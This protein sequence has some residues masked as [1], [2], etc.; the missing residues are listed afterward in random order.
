MN[1]TH[2]IICNGD[3]SFLYRFDNFPIYMGISSGI[4]EYKDQN[5]Y[6]CKQCGTI[7]LKDLISL[8]KLYSVPHNPA[9]G[10]TWQRHNRNFADYITKYGKKSILEIGGGNCKI[11]DNV[12]SN[13]SSI[14][15][16]I[17]DKHA[18]KNTR[19][20]VIF[21]D[22]FYNPDEILDNEIYDTIVMSHVF[23]HIYDP[24]LYLQS[25]NKNLNV[26]GRVIFSIPN[27]TKILED[28][29][30]NGLN[31]E[32]TYQIDNK[33]LRYLM[34]KNGFKEISVYDYS[35]HNIFA[36]FE[37]VSNM[38]ISCKLNCFDQNMSIWKDFI[39]YHTKTT[40]I[41][42]GLIKPYNNKF[43]FGCHVF[44][45]YL[46]HFGLD[47]NSFNGIIDNDP[48]KHGHRLYGTNLKTYPANIIEGMNSVAV[49]VKAGLYSKEITDSLLSINENCVII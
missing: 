49:I 33:I 48:N 13:N 46:L 43:L 21:I 44:S 27:I 18:Y 11:A 35:S 37:K 6:I 25:F 2:C 41:L 17:Y 10:Q 34:T 22:K 12:L 40:K 4:D 45:Q 23:E 3:I 24:N 28:K 15:Y 16:T 32:H 1:R 19:N 14:K 30:T 26:G 20:G 36:V 31:F 9:I 38:N 47:E 29:F 42:R 7:Q 8:E 5:W 39:N